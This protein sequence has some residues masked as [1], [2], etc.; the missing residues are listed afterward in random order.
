[1]ESTAARC[2]CCRT[3]LRVERRHESRVW[4][5][6]GCGGSAV[7]ISLLRRERDTVIVSHLWGAARAAQAAAG[8][9]CAMCNQ[10]AARASAELADGE[11]SVDVCTRCQ[12]A[13]LDPG[14]LDRMPA[15]P[16]TESATPAELPPEAKAAYAQAL[17]SM[18]ADRIRD[19]NQRAATAE[20]M[21]K[22]AAL[23]GKLAD[24]FVG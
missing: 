9:S 3:S 12:L 22:T 19:E 14:D 7:P 11:L 8:R 16:R 17:A 6:E 23:L 18:W 13:W 5:C 10:T 2:P 20:G 15:R 4:R 24:F 21:E 1:M